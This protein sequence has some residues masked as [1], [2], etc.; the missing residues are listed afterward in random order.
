MLNTVGK[1]TPCV[2]RFS[3]TGGEKG[4]ADTLRDPLGFATKFYTDEGNWDWVHLNVPYFFIRDPAKFPSFVH[5]QKRD[6]QTNLKNATMYW[7]W[8]T[9]NQESIHMVMWLFSENGTFRSYRHIN[10]YMGHAHKFVKPDGSFKYVHLYFDTDQGHE[11]MNNEEAQARMA[12][13]P[14]YFTRDLYESIRKGNFP[15]WTAKVQVLDPA[16]AEKFRYNIFDITK[17]WPLDDIP[18][19]PFGKLTLNRNPDNY[20]AEMEQLAFSPS[21]LVPG[22]EPSA[23]PV[24]QARMFAY[25]DTQRHRLGVNYQQIPVNQ[26]KNAFNPLQRDGAGTVNRNYGSFPSHLSTYR[27]V[28]FQPETKRTSR[29]EWVG[30]VSAEPLLDLTDVDFE[31]ARDDMWFKLG[32]DPHYEG[33]QPKLISN[34]SKHLCNADEG[35]RRKAYDMFRRVHEDLA[36]GVERESEALAALTPSIVV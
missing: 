2:T 1:K 8:V 25:P 34:I 26:P 17:Q 19:R 24:L 32:K 31:N 18:A 9:S 5:S 35:I 27:P 13:D 14:D 20:F 30:Q 6:P 15:T 16:D 23:D 36:S 21:H 4:S 28:R 10:S 3:T 33:W 22:I 7:D 11:Y 12:S 29:E